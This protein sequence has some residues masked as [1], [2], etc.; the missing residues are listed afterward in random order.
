[1]SFILRTL[2][3]RINDDDDDDV[4]VLGFRLWWATIGGTMFSDR[5]SVRQ[6]VRGSRKVFLPIS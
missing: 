5:M 1:M 2:L 4:F 6:S 3:W